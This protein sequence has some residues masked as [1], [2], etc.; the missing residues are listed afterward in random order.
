MIWTAIFKLSRCIEV[1]WTFVHSGFVLACFWLKSAILSQNER[2]NK[3]GTME[4][5][6]TWS[7]IS[8]PPVDYL[9]PPLCL[10]FAYPLGTRFLSGFYPE[11]G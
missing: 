7:W 4:L 1:G 3:P 8:L 10:S 5:Q 9:V 11:S 2:R 6:Q